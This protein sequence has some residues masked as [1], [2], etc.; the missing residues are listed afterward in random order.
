MPT[1]SMLRAKGLHTSNNYY[2][3]IPEGAL[4]VAENVNID[5][6]STIESRR[7]L[8][9]YGTIGVSPAND[10]AK[11]LLLYKERVL[12][13]YTTSIAYDNG[14]GTFTNFVASF[15]E[16]QAGL[17]IKFVEQNGNLYVTTSTGIRK[18]S[19]SSA[20]TLSSAKISNA[21]GIKA[22]GGTAVVNYA[23][24]GFFEGYS[25]V[26]YKI[27]WGTKDVNNNLIL[28][29]PSQPIEVTNQSS[30]S[31]TV[32][33]TF[34]VP[35]TV[36]TDYFYRIYRT[37]VFT[38]PTFADIDTLVVNDEYRLVYEQGY[39]T[40]TTITVNDIV[41]E[42]FRQGGTPLYTNEQ[43]GEGILQANE[44]PPFAKDIATYKNSVF[45]SNTRTNYKQL[46]DM[47]GV[48]GLLRFGAIDDTIEVTNITYSAP[49]TTITFSDPHGLV[50]GN[51]VVILDSG[52]AT[53]DGVQIIDDV[54]SPTTIEI[55]ADGTGATATNV[56]IYGSY[57]TITKGMNSDRYYF[58]GR[59][60]INELTLPA[61]YAG[62][63]QTYFQ[64]YSS[65]DIV[66]YTVY[67][68]DTAQP[69]TAPSNSEIDGTI[70]IKVDVSV[71]DNTP[72][73]IAEKVA[74]AIE[75]NSFD[76]GI[77][78]NMGV[79]TIVNSNSGAAS[80]IDIT[81][82]NPVI[83][84]STAN[85]Q[86]G[87]GEDV[88][89]GYVR[90]SSLPSPSQRIDDTARSLT[91]VI[92]GNS[93]GDINAYYISGS[94]DAPGKM[95]FEARTLDTTPFTIVASDASTGAMFT[96]DIT[97]VATSE[98]EE[99]AN[100]IYYSKTSQPE[101]VPLVNYFDIGPQDK[102]ILRILG[103]RDS[104]FILK[105]E[106]IYRL[107]GENPTNF[108]V[109]LFDGSTILTAP[110][111][112]TV[113]DNQ[114]FCLSSQ[115]VVRISETGVD[116]IS[117]PIQD[118]INMSTSPRYT[119]FST[120]S[121]AISY[122]KD[123]AYILWLPESP[124]D[125]TGT[126]AVRF[127]TKTNTWTTWSKKGNA[128][129]G[130]V[131]TDDNKLYI[132]PDDLNI[133]EI[134]RKQLRRVDFADREY[135]LN[136]LANGV[137]NDTLSIQLSSLTNVELGD[138]L[139]QQQYVTAALIERIA[140]KFSLDAGVPSNVGNQ[141]KDFYRN[142]DVLPGDSLQNKLTELITQLDSDIGSSYLVVYSTNILTFQT[143][144]NTLINNLNLDPVLLHTN[145]TPATSLVEFELFITSLDQQNSAVTVALMQPIATG[146]ITH[147][148]SIDCNVVYAPYY[149]GEPALLKHVRDATIMFATAT[150]TRGS[151]NYNTDLS[152][153]F[154][155]V[156]FGM[157]GTGNW[158][159]WIFDSIT[160]GGEGTARPF[161]T[162]IPR[163]KQRCRF[164]RTQ[165]KHKAAF[166]EFRILGIS[167]TFEANSE[168]AYK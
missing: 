96:P 123:Y 146:P 42:D 51:E 100:R 30:L 147:F 92:S 128:R 114:I 13:H 79:L 61:Y 145:Y 35:T 22:L 127:S 59:P 125:D 144:F 19:A 41:P 69:D 155:G 55:T 71:S 164:I 7:G 121:F 129:C 18:V 9:Q 118:F 33:I 57:I 12:A 105:E 113:M 66:T 60:E 6:L 24:R 158:G 11:Q 159:T 74:T 77:V 112:A 117:D 150:V 49:T 120:A 78:Q 99:K 141:N 48:G 166:D 76:F 1:T 110:D 67:F 119:D 62:I 95:L 20:A 133:V 134:E 47:I 108:F 81:T 109:T 132:G 28:G 122:I 23:T 102:A 107:T 167:Y 32:D 87:H 88:S 143:Q 168:R 152:T 46:I 52:A 165:F 43:S 91:R 101:A 136:V 93:S 44:P 72:T 64:L 56:S 29:S 162:L 156:D 27:V 15:I 75:D 8:K 3:E 89:Q 82:I 135:T 36:T 116:I 40:G 37:A 65:E 161:R 85:I 98:N 160:W 17:R 151:L 63:D 14:S 124:E 10:T 163:K 106:G 154:E 70:V 54:P 90:L 139:V 34:D 4:Q 31:G 103:L 68:H 130:I 157:E 84:I 115:G 53:L 25:K 21:G 153:N 137:D 50:T 126:Y 26:A 149:F 2:S 45:Y 58:V 104:L 111:T 73:L 94:E 138:A 140:K 97:T 80:N 142:F 16:A 38:A 148:E 39:S 86:D 131:N 5:R 83:G